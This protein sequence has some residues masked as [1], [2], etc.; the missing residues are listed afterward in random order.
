MLQVQLYLWLSG[1][2]RGVII[3]VTPSKFREFEV[4]PEFEDDE[5]VAILVD[6][7]LSPKYDWECNY[8]EFSS[9]CNICKR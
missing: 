2:E 8:C 6:E 5:D 7:W 9:V 4:Y 1:R 3:Y